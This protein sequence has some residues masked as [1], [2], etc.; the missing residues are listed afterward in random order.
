MRQLSKL[1]ADQP[2][3][4]IVVVEVPVHPS[5][6]LLFPGGETEQQQVRQQLADQITSRGLLYWPLET[7][8]A[9]PADGWWDRNHVN[10]VGIEI[11]STWLGQRLAQAVQQGELQD[12]AQ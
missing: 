10:L 8:P 1:D 6:S 12:P 7:Q 4:Q 9:I 5:F 3:L 11:Y 2:K